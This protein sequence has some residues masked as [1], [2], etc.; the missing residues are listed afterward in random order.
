MEFFCLS[1]LLALASSIFVTLSFLF[2]NNRSN[3][4]PA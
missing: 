3:F 1:L 4:H 2:C